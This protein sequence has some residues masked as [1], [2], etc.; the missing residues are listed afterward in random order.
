MTV[1]EPNYSSRPSARDGFIIVA[2]LW[3]LIALA[4]LAS[5]YSIYINNSALAVSVT[6]DRLQ[7]E[8]LVSASLELTAYR[9]TDPK[10]DLRPTRGRFSFRLGRA[11]VVVDFSSETARIDLN[12]AP[13]V[14]LTG[15]FYA[16]G[17]S[18]EDADR[19][20]DRV[21]GWRTT[22]NTGTSR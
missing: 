2:V 1:Y 7:A 13:K 19:Y 9:L 20:A 4:T 11:N 16:L 6:D 14:L 10:N 5:I 17:A 21:I 12:A 3:I 22:P 18:D 15:F 8:A